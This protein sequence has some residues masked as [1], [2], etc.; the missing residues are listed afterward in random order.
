MNKINCSTVYELLDIYPALLGTEISDKQCDQLS[1]L[2][3]TC[4]GENVRGILEHILSTKDLLSPE[5]R[6]TVSRILRIDA[7]RL[8]N[9]YED[10]GS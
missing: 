9:S 4:D 3:K 6:Q 8:R 10:D 1:E 2:L 5:A 7:A